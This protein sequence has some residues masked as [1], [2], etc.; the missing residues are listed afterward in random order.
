[1]VGTGKGIRSAQRFLIPGLEDILQK[2]ETCLY[3]GHGKTLD[4][5]MHWLASPA[6]VIITD[7]E[8][9]YLGYEKV[10][11][12]VRNS[13]KKT[14]WG[15]KIRP[16]AYDPYKQKL[17]KS[18]ERCLREGEKY[19]QHNLKRLREIS[20]ENCTLESKLNVLEG[21]SFKPGSEIEVNGSKLT[22]EVADIKNL[23][24]R[25]KEVDLTIM[26]LV[27]HLI[28]DWEKALNECLK[29]SKELRISPLLKKVKGYCKRNSIELETEFIE[30][31]YVGKMKDLIGGDK[32]EEIERTRKVISEELPEVQ[33]VGYLKSRNAPL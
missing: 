11:S 28:D 22:I 21:E 33:E 2:G 15:V 13:P 18:G 9:D 5:F 20:R 7:K 10:A 32:P 12:K 29:V 24:E 14:N 4:G 26:N 23:G 17:Y 25:F 16:T 8:E 6:D 31:D 27:L 3:V 19:Y 1:M 30:L